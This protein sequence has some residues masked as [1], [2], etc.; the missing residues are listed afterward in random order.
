MAEFARQ[1]YGENYYYEIVLK[2]DAMI[3]EVLRLKI[4]AQIIRSI[5]IFSLSQSFLY[6]ISSCL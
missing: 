5:F 1:L 3:K 6:R 2:E 4:K